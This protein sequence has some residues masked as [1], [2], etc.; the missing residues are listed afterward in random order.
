MKYAKR[1]LTGFYILISVFTFLSLDGCVRGDYREEGRQ[2]RYYYRDGKWHRSGLFGTSVVVSALAIGAFIDSLPPSH[3]TIVVEGTPYYHDDRYYYRESSRGGYV[4]V[5]EP[6]IVQ[7]HPQSKNG[8]RGDR[9]DRSDNM[10][11][12]E[13][14]GLHHQ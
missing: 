4:V 3:T 5:S 6:V 11:N 14:R 7:S 13:N 10:H 12:E 9:G 1:M 8:E 2:D